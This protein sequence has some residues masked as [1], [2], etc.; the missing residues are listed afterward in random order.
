MQRVHLPGGLGKRRYLPT[1]PVPTGDR[2]TA[3]SRD[4]PQP[5]G[6]LAG[7]GQADEGDR[8]EADV[9]PPTGDHRPQDPPP[10]A[11]LVDDEVQAVAVGVPAGPVPSH[12]D[13]RQA[14]MRMA[15]M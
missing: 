6:V 3:G 15:A 13:G 12:R 1:L 9:A 7:L 11:R 8:P 4:P 10:R 5:R 2:I 14:L